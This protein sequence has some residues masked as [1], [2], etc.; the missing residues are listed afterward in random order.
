MSWFHTYSHCGETLNELCDDV[1]AHAAHK[2]AFRQPRF[3]VA[4]EWCSKYE[5]NTIK[6]FYLMMLPDNLLHAYPDISED[7]ASV[8]ATPT[9]RTKWALPA[10][11]I[12]HEIDH[13]P[14]RDGRGTEWVANEV[15]AVSYNPCTLKSPEARISF[16]HQ[17][18]A[19]DDDMTGVQEPK[20]KAFSWVIMD[21]RW[22]TASSG[23]DARGQYA[24]ECWIRLNKQWATADGLRAQPDPNH[25]HVMF[26][27]PN[28]LIVR[29][30][31]EAFRFSQLSPE[32]HILKAKRRPLAIGPT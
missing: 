5:A 7:L 10:E 6:L 20:T 17:L 3:T 22:W 19:D 1:V 31:M 32:A 23:A 28:L 25:I 13:L 26:A 21:G 30:D 11:E 16:M 18:D 4:S 14:E 24:C 27:E 15:H 12:A 8:L 2:P 29:L 9:A